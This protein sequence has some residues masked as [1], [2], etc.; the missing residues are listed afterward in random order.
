MKHIANRVSSVIVLVALALRA[1]AAEDLPTLARTQDRDALQGQIEEAQET[2]Q[3]H[4]HGHVI[5]GRVVLDGPGDPRDVIAQ[6]QILEDGYFAGETKDLV[7]PVG[8]RMH[9]YAPLDLRLEG[10][11]GEVVDVGT[12]HMKPLPKEE[13]LTLRGKVRLEG[14]DTAD[15]ASVQ[16]SVTH[17]PVNTPSNGT[18][19]RP[20]WPA[21]IRPEI[22]DSGAFVAKYLS[23]VEYYCQVK[24]PGFVTKSFPVAFESGKDIDLGEIHLERPLEITLTYLV[25]DKPPF[26]PAQMRK[27]VLPGGDRWKATPEIY[28][29]DL[30]F[31]QKDGD[32]FFDYAHGHCFLMDLG[33]GSIKDLLQRAAAERPQDSP[34]GQK[35]QNGHVYLMNQTHWKHWVLFEVTIKQNS[36]SVD[37]DKE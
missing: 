24:A 17:G 28:G 34:R 23:P 21:D 15:G 26:D 37:S 12:I 3:R 35:V 25:A 7:R 29:W 9:G 6:M 19:G 10:L 22:I 20:S 14:R 1:A 13:L 18:S 32:I 2:I 30:E 36:N 8:F 5:V 31:K 11:S 4:R 16:L 33:E 27:T